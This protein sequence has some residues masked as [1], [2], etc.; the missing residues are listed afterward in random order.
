MCH[1]AGLR[2]MLR[3]DGS[4]HRQPTSGS[5]GMRLSHLLE[6]V[7]SIILALVQRAIFREQIYKSDDSDVSVYGKLLT[8]VFDTDLC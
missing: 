2:Y 8:Y 6:W 3:C 1:W 5:G 7:L 4:I